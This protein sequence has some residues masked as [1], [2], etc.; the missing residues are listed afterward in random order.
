MHLLQMMGCNKIYNGKNVYIVR[1]LLD[2]LATNNGT[3]VPFF[4]W[5]K[6]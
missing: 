1:L 6:W 2:V 5:M 4:L 3:F